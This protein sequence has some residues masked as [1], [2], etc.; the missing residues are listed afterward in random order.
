MKQLMRM[1]RYLLVG[2]AVML[3]TTLIAGAV[4]LF[5]HINMMAD[6]RLRPVTTGLILL[7]TGICGLA[8]GIAAAVICRHRED[9]RPWNN[10]RTG[11]WPPGYRH[12]MMKTSGSSHRLSG[13]CRHACK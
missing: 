9:I 12:P 3:T 10:S 8:A 7:L 1:P 2:L 11:I 6:F 5:L 13:G 4:V